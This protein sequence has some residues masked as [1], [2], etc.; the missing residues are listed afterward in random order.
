MED[1][2]NQLAQA[3]S[4]MTVEQIADALMASRH[5]SSI[6]DPMMV[7]AFIKNAA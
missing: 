6:D 1:L 4:E 2:L 7:A 3:A 5:G